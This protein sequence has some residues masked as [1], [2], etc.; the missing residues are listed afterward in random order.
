MEETHSSTSGART[1]CQLCGFETRD[2]NRHLRRDCLLNT[3]QALESLFVADSNSVYTCATIQTEP[4]Y[5]YF[6]ENLDGKKFSILKNKIKTIDRWKVASKTPFACSSALQRYPFRTIVFTDKEG[7]CIGI[8]TM[9]AP[10]KEAN[11]G[12]LNCSDF[13]FRPIP[14]DDR[15]KVA[16]SRIWC[17][18][19][20]ERLEYILMRVMLEDLLKFAIPGHAQLETDEVVFHRST[21]DSTN[22]YHFREFSDPICN[23]KLVVKVYWT[24]HEE[25]EDHI[26]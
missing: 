14:R 25:Q 23:R 4:I 17:V 15:I 5:T 20:F 18:K 3:F 19:A 7:K 6:L 16:V 12:Y 8:L 2:M 1:A 10:D 9:E 24:D 26:E 13:K 21:I 11:Y 22:A